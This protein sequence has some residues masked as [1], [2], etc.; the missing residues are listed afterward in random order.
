MINEIAAPK[1]S[2]NWTTAYVWSP[3]NPFNE[4]DT[5]FIKRNLELPDPNSKS[6]NWWMSDKKELMNVSE[7][8]MRW[9]VRTRASRKATLAEARKLDALVEREVKIA[10]K[11][12]KVM[13]KVS[14]LP[15]ARKPPKLK[16]FEAPKDKK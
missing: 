1:A 8:V 10:K 13:D 2:E 5:V 11:Y 7:E 3:L 16:N 15:V 6:N 12:R 9:T 14:P 4:G